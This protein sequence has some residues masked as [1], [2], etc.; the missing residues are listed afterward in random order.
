MRPQAG[1]ASLNGAHTKEGGQVSSLAP[2]AWGSKGWGVGSKEHGGPNPGQ[3][4]NKGLIGPEQILMDPCG[5]GRPPCGSQR[6]PAVPGGSWQLL[7]APG[8]SWADD[9]VVEAFAWTFHKNTTSKP[10]S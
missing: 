10:S 5:S 1:K 7:A 4:R 8:H 9:F 3:A 2:I 6:F